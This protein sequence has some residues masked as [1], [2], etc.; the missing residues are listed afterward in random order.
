MEKSR[1]FQGVGGV[2]QSPLERKIQWGGG[3]NW[4]EP[5]VGGGYGYFLEPHNINN[6]IKVKAT[7]N[8]A[9]STFLMVR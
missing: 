4:K 5:S 7:E 8:C 2:T 1:K 3:S 9:Q 6:K